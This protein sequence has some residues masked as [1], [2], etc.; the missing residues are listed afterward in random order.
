[1]KW[2][3]T[4]VQKS[5][6][7]EILASFQLKPSWRHLLLPFFCEA[8]LHRQLLYLKK[9]TKKTPTTISS[10]CSTLTSFFSLGPLCSLHFAEHLYSAPFHHAR[11]PAGI[12]VLSASLIIWPMSR[13]Q[14]Y[15]Q[16]CI[17]NRLTV[18]PPAIHPPRKSCSVALFILTIKIRAF[19][20][21]LDREPSRIRESVI[22]HRRTPVD[23]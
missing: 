6:I 21:G 16:R 11:L 3:V 8:A 12:S 17:F 14:L 22:Y 20:L 19:N 1:M 2:W 5:C 23:I 13:Y 10:F 15:Q 4:N 9:K 7:S 18:L